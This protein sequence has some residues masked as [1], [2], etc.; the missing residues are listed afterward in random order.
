METVAFRI[1]EGSN[2]GWECYG[3]DA[4]ALDSWDGDQE[5]SSFTVIFD[6]KDQTVYEVQAHDYSNQRAYR[7][8]NPNFAKKHRKEAKRRDSNQNEAWE[9]VDYVDL[10]V[11]EDWLRKAS[12]IFSNESYDTRISVPIDLEDDLMFELMKMAHE[13]DVTLNE[14]VEIILLEVIARQDGITLED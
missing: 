6:T 14:M 2:Y 10:E 4:Y 12:A 8:I 5:G 1:T 3:P 9:D 11:A 7:M 13:K